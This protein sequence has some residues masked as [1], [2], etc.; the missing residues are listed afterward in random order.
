MQF[1]RSIVAIVST[2]VLTAGLGLSLTQGAFA[3]NVNT[4]NIKGSASQTTIKNLKSAEERF[5]AAQ[6]KLRDLTAQAEVAQNNLY[7]TQEDLKQTQEAIDQ[8]KKDIEIKTKE[9]TSARELLS[10]RI[11]AN[12]KSGNASILSVILDATDFTDFVN[13]I[14][15]MDK[16]S[17]QD[18]KMIEQVRTLKK[19]LE[20]HEKSLDARLKEQSELE[21]RQKQEKE[22]ADNLVIQQ[23]EFT[24]N[25]DDEVKALYEKKRKEE[26]ADREAKIK[27]AQEAAR[28]AAEAAEAARKA[29]GVKNGSSS[30][31]NINNSVPGKPSPNVVNNAL[32]YIGKPYVWGGSGPNGFDCSGL[33]MRAYSEAGISIPHSSLA[34]YNAVKAK[35]NLKTDASKLVPG[36]LVFYYSPVH[37]VGIYIGNGKMVHAPT[38]GQSVTVAP[39]N[40]WGAF[41]GGG[42]W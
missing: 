5:Q 16:V 24:S 28:K 32:R 3:T 12:Y 41:V 17:E 21:E 6:E 19:D 27:A 20:D 40:V 9:L 18:A 31:G 42:S 13:R 7:Q 36:D 25:L 33:T 38:F 8:T 37:H 14:Y 26:E 34:Q 39:V 4:S 2:A 30:S 1:K 10:E 23:A 11:A 29:A 22:K 15:Y 35:G